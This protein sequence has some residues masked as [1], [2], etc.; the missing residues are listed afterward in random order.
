V[1]AEEWAFRVEVCE[2]R[3]TIPMR[4]QLFEAAQDVLLSLA[5]FNTG[6]QRL[7]SVWDAK[8]PLDA[9]AVEEKET[10]EATEEPS[11]S[12][13]EATRVPREVIG[14]LETHAIR[15]LGVRLVDLC[16]RGMAIAARVDIHTENRDL[17][18]PL[19][20]N[21]ERKRVLRAMKCQPLSE[22]FVLT[23]EGADSPASAPLQALI[24]AAVAVLDAL[25]LSTAHISTGITQ[26][27]IEERGAAMQEGMRRTVREKGQALPP[28]AL[29]QYLLLIL[30]FART[31]SML[32]A[33]SSLLAA[34]IAP[35]ILPVLVP[36]QSNLCLQALTLHP[37][38]VSTQARAAIER[39]IA[40]S[41]QK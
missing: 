37:D 22:L 35:H 2:S 26:E 40:Q 32:H 11:L 6:I 14:G 41:P 21:A 20:S 34:H 19:P 18:A 5:L 38:T 7:G 23:L 1:F 12:S 24:D 4:A 29:V 33:P 25:R 28:Q 17:E 13:A 30:Y 10:D 3:L 8:Q 36:A 16:I 15:T 31:H 27:S 9:S 39:L